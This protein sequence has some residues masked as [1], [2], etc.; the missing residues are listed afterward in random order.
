MRGERSVSGLLSPDALDNFG[1]A[2]PPTLARCRF[3][4]PGGIGGEPPPDP[5]SNSEVKVPSADGTMS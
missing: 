1:G 3:R 5:I 2:L 4:R